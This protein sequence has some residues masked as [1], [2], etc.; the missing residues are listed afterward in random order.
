[1]TDQTY[2]N[3]RYLDAIEDHLLIYD[4]AMGTSIQRY[5]LTAEDFGGP[6]LDGNNDWLSITRPDVIEEIHASFFEV[7]SEVVETNTFRGNRIT[8]A[9]YG[10]QERVLELNRAAAELARRVADRFE[11][12]TGV[13][14]FVAGSIG[15]TGKLPSSDDPDLSDV[16]FDELAEVFYEETRSLSLQMEERKLEKSVAGSDL[17]LGLRALFDDRT[18]YAYTNQID[19]QNGKKASVIG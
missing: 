13:P 12:E 6:A 3:R 5:D 1:M 4:G 14:R 18:V 8:Q 17:G 19:E 16:T 15:P 2:T 9:E 10:L 11:K 7:G